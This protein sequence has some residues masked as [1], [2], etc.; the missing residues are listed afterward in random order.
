MARRTKKPPKEK[1]PGFGRRLRNR[2]RTLGELGSDAV[3]QPRVIPGKAHGWFRH[4]A[5]RVWRLRGGGLYAC[6]FIVTFLYLE[7]VTIFGDV[8]ESSGVIDFLATELFEFFFRFVIES[9]M[10]TINAF[11]W[12]VYVIA[13]APPW[14]M[15]GLGAAFVL[16]DR[17]IKKPVEE[18]LFRDEEADV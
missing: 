15:I 1:K 17:V 6:G 16:F 9:L 8:A 14:G 7:I 3:H 11:I 4:W 5:G 10:N 13:F 2:A 18:Y 12:P